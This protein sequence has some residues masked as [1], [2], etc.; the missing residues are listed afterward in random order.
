MA[1]RRKEE[2]DCSS[3]FKCRLNL[4]DVFELFG[5][6]FSKRPKQPVFYLILRRPHRPGWPPE[7]RRRWNRGCRWT[8]RCGREGHPEPSGSLRSAWPGP[9]HAT[10]VSSLLNFLLSITRQ[11]PY[12]CVLGFA[13][14][15]SLENHLILGTLIGW[16]FQNPSSKC[17]G[18]GLHCEGNVSGNTRSVVIKPTMKSFVHH[19]KNH[20]K[21]SHRFQKRF[22]PNFDH[23]CQTKRKCIRFGTSECCAYVVVTT[24]V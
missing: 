18:L 2:M 14:H 5:A 16:Q 11:S 24:F 9:W 17:I 3:T 19:Q 6:W 15:E 10:M 12:D 1:F 13:M 21:T 7:T 4:T 22:L 8:P 20:Q 23:T